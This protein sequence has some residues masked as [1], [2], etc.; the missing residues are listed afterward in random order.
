MQED[1][2]YTTRE[3]HGLKKMT[4][5]LMSQWAHTTARRFVSLLGFIYCGNLVI[6]LARKI[7]DYT[8]M[9]DWRYFKKAKIEFHR[10]FKENYQ[11]IAI[12]CNLKV[13]NYLDVTLNLNDGSY[14]PYNKPNDEIMYIHKESNHPPAIT[15]QLP[16]S[17]ESRLRKISSSKK[18]FDESSKVFQD[19]LSRSGY[20][21]VL[22]YD[23]PTNN[24][25]SKNR[26]RNVIWFNPPYSRSVA[27]NVGKTFLNLLE[28]HFPKHHKFRKIFNRNNVKISY[29]CMPNLKSK[30]NQHNKK[31]L[32][33]HVDEAEPDAPR[34]CNCP[35]NTECPLQNACLDKD[36]LYTAELSSNIPNYGKKV[37]KG[38]CSTTFKERLA[39]HKKAFK[40]VTYENNTEL[41]KE[42]W[43]IKRKGGEYVIKWSK[44]S[45]YQSYK[46]ENKA[47]SL[48]YQEKLAISLFEGDF[49]LNK[50]NEIISRCRH[51]AKFKLKNL[52]F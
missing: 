37:Y 24:C 16:F 6:S 38:I 43:N 10:I 50:K 47:C 31:I 41:S 22:T 12:Q 18:V 19:A 25:R 5:I 30:I 36:I 51:R 4:K 15:K 49:L 45:N 35:R 3:N 34:K 17:V 33:K 7:L 23:S 28:K 8:E 27:T 48:C 14:R 29:S 52:I 20:D 42:V 9:T 13:V 26:K 2:S 39:N 46:P 11:D 21:H 44:D 40:N 32:Q 1:L